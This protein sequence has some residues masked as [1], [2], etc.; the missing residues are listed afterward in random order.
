VFVNAG[1]VD[2]NGLQFTRDR[3]AAVDDVAPRRLD[4]LS[5]MDQ[6]HAR[7]FRENAFVASPDY[8]ARLSALIE[9]AGFDRDNAAT[10]PA[11]A[12]PGIVRRREKSPTPTNA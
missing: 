2:P 6:A 12:A 1:F 7:I 10:A 8:A 4:D 5:A 11:H 3:L 9:A